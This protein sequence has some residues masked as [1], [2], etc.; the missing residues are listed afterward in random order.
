MAAV[1]AQSITNVKT[2]A[3]DLTRDMN[4]VYVRTV[5]FPVEDGATAGTA[6]LT[7]FT[8]PKNTM[9]LSGAFNPGAA[10]GTC[11]FKFSLATD[12]DICAATTANTADTFVK[13]AT[14]TQVVATA[15]RQVTFTTATAATVAGTATL[16]LICVPIG[17]ED[18]PYTTQNT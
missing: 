11:T 10:Q 12:G 1:S 18:S 9:I 7:N 2:A 5:T 4:G 3:A 13:L 6:N 15:D 17:T 16:S 8:I 14:P